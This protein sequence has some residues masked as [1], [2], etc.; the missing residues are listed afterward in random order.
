MEPSSGLKGIV[1]QRGLFIS[2]GWQFSFQRTDGS[3]SI[4]SVR[5]GVFGN[6]RTASPV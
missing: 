6:E 4:V 1:L 3:T 2:I 5:T